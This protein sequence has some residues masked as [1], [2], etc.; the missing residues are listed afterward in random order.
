MR[1]HEVSISRQD[2]TIWRSTQKLGKGTLG[3]VWTEGCKSRIPLRSLTPCRKDLSRR[4]TTS[5]P[6]VPP[7]LM[8]LHGGGGNMPGQPQ[9]ALLVAPCITVAAYNW[10]GPV[11]WHKYGSRNALK[12]VTFPATISIHLPTPPASTTI[13]S[14]A[15]C[16]QWQRAMTELCAT[17]CSCL[18]HAATS[19]EDLTA[20]AGGLK[21]FLAH[22]A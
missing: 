1:S 15:A 2:A 4:P 11:C 22:V 19:P 10:C 20:Q 21:R 5:M 12:R 18:S 3:V 6:T 7:L 14:S 13:S 17:S 8:R 9:I 16:I